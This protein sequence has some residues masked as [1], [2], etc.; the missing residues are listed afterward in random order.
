MPNR[1]RSGLRSMAWALAVPAV[2]LASSASNSG[3]GSSSPAGASD[4]GTDGGTFHVDI[5]LTSGLITCPN[6]YSGWSV[7]GG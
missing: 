6:K 4:G 1:K 3:C 5:S 7:G 2:L